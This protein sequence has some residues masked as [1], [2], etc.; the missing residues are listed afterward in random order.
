MAGCLALV[1]VFLAHAAIL[2]QQPVVGTAENGDFWR[3][4]RP[5]G[6]VS[7]DDYR[8][9]DHKYASQTYGVTAA[10]LGEGFSSAAVIAAAARWLG[11][12]AATLDIRQVGGVYLALFAAAFAAGLWGGVPALLCALLAWAAL[13]VSYALYFN[14]FFADSAALLGILGIALALL[15]WPAEPSVGGRGCLL[16]ALLVLAALI[17]GFS[18]QLYMLTPL[19]AAVALLVWPSRAWAAHVRGAALSLVMLALGG[20]LA[21]WHFTAGSGHR[22]PAANNHHAVFWGLASVTDDPA[23][24]LVELGVDPRHAVL[25]GTSYFRLDAEQ[26]QT[27]VDALR[28]LSRA[29]L[30]LAYLRDPRRAGRALALAVPSLR[31][32]ATADPNFSD[33]TRRP[34]F[35]VGWWQFAR[36][37][38]AL[39]PVAVV[40]LLAGVVGL[41]RAARGRDW[42]GPHAALAFLLLNAAV[43]LI[44][45]V[46]GD[47]LP[48]LHRHLIGVRFSVDLALALVVYGAYRR[49]RD[50]GRGSVRPPEDDRAGGDA[51]RAG[52]QHVLDA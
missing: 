3:V 29:R 8:S 34:A 43:L 22:F 37:R 14:S 19:L 30:A 4:M 28:D 44:A 6:I 40:L 10:R 25:A 31:L 11:G 50:G 7:F 51:G 9:V 13:D 1:A 41:V 47:G 33:R 46:L 24:A 12:G 45:C 27:S 18:K 20:G 17:A 38:G 21:L 32:T 52:D 42:C 39:Y 2:M 23:Q 49:W 15:A 48:S 16:S 36:L 5:A 26:R 35:Y